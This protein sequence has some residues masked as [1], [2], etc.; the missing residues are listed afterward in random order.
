MMLLTKKARM[1]EHLE[2]IGKDNWS[3]FE[4]L[5]SDHL[6]GKLSGKLRQ[7]G[8]DKPEIYVDF[9]DGYKCIGILGKCRQNYVDIQIEETAFSIGCDPVEPD[10]HELYSLENEELFFAAVAQKLNAL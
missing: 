10:E 2:T 5:L 7:I 8:I 6:D 1:R 9:L 3:A 4:R